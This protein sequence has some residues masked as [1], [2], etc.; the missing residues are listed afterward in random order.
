MS[1]GLV[2]AIRLGIGP[3]AELGELGVMERVRSPFFL[4]PP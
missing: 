1:F 3:F 4:F 2:H